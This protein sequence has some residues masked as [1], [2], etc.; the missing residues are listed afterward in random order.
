M[1]RSRVAEEQMIGILRL[2]GGRGEAAIG[3]IG[4]SEVA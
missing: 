4:E 1:K 3:L 2:Q